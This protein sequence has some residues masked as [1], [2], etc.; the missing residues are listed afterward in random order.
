MAAAICRLLLYM[1]RLACGLAAYIRCED[2]EP[3]LLLFGQYVK[4]LANVKRLG[5]QATSCCAQGV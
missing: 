3:V 2:I 1:R 4:G 5:H